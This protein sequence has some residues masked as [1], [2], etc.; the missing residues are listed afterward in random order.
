MSNYV[1]CLM[2]EGRKRA[3]N[4][5]LLLAFLWCWPPTSCTVLYVY[6]QRVLC[7]YPLFLSPILQL[8]AARLVEAQLATIYRSSCNYILLFFLSLRKIF[9]SSRHGTFLHLRFAR[10][11]CHLPY[12]GLLYGFNYIFCA[13]KEKKN[14][15][16]R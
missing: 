12:A 5:S 10:R 8:T 1:E 6:V 15:C 9:F 13:I 2:N 3:T 14:N 16:I 7:I 4:G 11:L